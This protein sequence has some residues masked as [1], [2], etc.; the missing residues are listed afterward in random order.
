MQAVIHNMIQCHLRIGRWDFETYYCFD[1][2][3]VPPV[4]ENW[5]IILASSWTSWHSE[6]RI[7]GKGFTLK[8]KV[9]LKDFFH[10]CLSFMCL[11]R[12]SFL[13]YDTPSHSSH[14]YWG[15]SW[16]LSWLTQ[17]SLFLYLKGHLEHLKGR[18]GSCMTIWFLRVVS[19]LKVKLH[20]W[21]RCWRSDCALWMFKWDLRFERCLKVFP[22]NSQGIVFLTFECL[23]STCPF[24]SCLDLKANPHSAQT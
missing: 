10:E 12:L 22:H 13:V 8:P 4:T 23:R 19:D 15:L 3:L 11:F 24:I 9:Y 2:V 16:E 7:F 21:H 20:S 6:R 1:V 14:E 17:A 5:R 18:L